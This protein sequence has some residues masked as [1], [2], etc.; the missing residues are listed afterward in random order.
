MMGSLYSFW[1]VYCSAEGHTAKN[2]KRKSCKVPGKH[3]CRISSSDRYGKAG[4]A[5]K[6]EDRVNGNGGRSVAP[7]AR[8]ESFM[9]FAA[10]EWLVRPSTW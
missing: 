1:G 8:D 6:S 10:T 3:T 4:L 5:G 7:F 9:A 2:R